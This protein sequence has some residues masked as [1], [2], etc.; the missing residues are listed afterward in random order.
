M[1]L[2]GASSGELISTYHFTNEGTKL[3]RF[4]SH[5]PEGDAAKNR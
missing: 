5:G 3:H 2:Y 4:A 1:K